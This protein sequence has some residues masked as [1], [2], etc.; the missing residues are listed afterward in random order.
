M[1]SGDKKK[2]ADRFSSVVEQ[3]LLDTPHS[4]GVSDGNPGQF[5]GCGLWLALTFGPWVNR[6]RTPEVHWLRVGAHSFQHHMFAK[7]AA[8]GG[9]WMCMSVC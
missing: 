1:K 9:V 8:Q 3:C 2:K 5:S 4:S 7:A 6:V